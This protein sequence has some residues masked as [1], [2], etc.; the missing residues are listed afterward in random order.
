MTYGRTTVLC[1]EWVGLV[2]V[3][4]AG[5]GGQLGD[6]S[7]P[8]RGAVSARWSPACPRAAA[9]AP[10]SVRPQDA[11]RPGGR[12][13]CCLCAASA[14]RSQVRVAES[15][16]IIQNKLFF[17]CFY[18]GILEHLQWLSILFEKTGRWAMKNEPICWLSKSFISPALDS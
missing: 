11:R 16:L 15:Q 12:A 7:P 4:R 10:R 13:D 17:F 6:D 5:R 18:I 3:S 8:W 2:V 14:R 1:K 9:R